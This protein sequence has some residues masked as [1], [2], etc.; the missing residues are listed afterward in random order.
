MLTHD[1]LQMYSRGIA[2]HHAGLH[3]SLKALVEELYEAKLIKAPPKSPSLAPL[4]IGMI[5]SPV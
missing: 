4:K 2:F 3:V 1:L 5:N